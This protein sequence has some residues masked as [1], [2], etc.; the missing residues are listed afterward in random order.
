M[1][2][3]QESG[4][5]KAADMVAERST[6]TEDDVD[7]MESDA[8]RAEVRRLR[9]SRDAHDSDDVVKRKAELKSMLE[10]LGYGVHIMVGRSHDV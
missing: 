4:T 1:T 5:K 2:S 3:E 10:E 8:L 7:L 9:I 6:E